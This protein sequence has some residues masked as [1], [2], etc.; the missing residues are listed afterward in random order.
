MTSLIFCIEQGERN[1][2]EGGPVRRKSGVENPGEEPTLKETEIER[3][4]RPLH[5]CFPLENKLVGI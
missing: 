1:G 5:E 2:R 3:L 4:K